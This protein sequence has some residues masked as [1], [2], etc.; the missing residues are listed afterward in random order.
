MPY[1]TIFKNWNRYA[2]MVFMVGFMSLLPSSSI[3]VTN[4]IVGS[5][6][7]WPTTW[8]PLN[9]L[10]DPNDGTTRIQLDFVGDTTNVCGYYANTNGYVFFRQRVRQDAF[11]DSHFVLIDLVGKDYNTTTKTLV[12]GNDG[13]PDY[14]FT[15]DSKSVQVAEH[16]LEMMVRAVVGASWG[17]I[18]M[19]DID[20]AAGSK[21]TNDINGNS[22]LADG[23]LRWIDSQSTTNF[24]TT[25]FIDYAVS[26]SY[27]Q[28]YTG[29]NSNQ[30]WRTTFASIANATDHNAI[31]GD[32]AGGASPA[33]SVSNG[34]VSVYSTTT[35]SG[36]DLRAYQC[37]GGV[38]VEFT[39]YDVEKDGTVRL[40]LLGP[41]G[42]SI[43]EGTTNIVAGATVVSRFIVPGLTLGGTYSFKIVDEVN[44]EWTAT[45]VTVSEFA[46]KGVSMSLSGITLSFSSQP[47]Q[48]YEIQWTSQ[49][50]GEW[51]TRTNVT[52]VS[53][54]TSVFVTYPGPTTSAGFFRVRM[55]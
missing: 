22:R 55:Q 19:D 5:Y 18:Q 7:N 1:S 4:N 16:G 35:S 29:L 13:L 11:S 31:N 51:Q 10:N 14:A 34:W 32:V 50:G 45:D 53:Q 46:M 27:L 9:G 43:W 2:A 15:W 26:W 48:K 3:A 23:Y 42:D 52:A 37:A 25:T 12:V 17:S 54:N 21:G 28:A 6:S 40:I 39:S 47:R 8:I 41:A 20:Y 38:T 33:S 36:V 30:S 49:L 44:K 24:G